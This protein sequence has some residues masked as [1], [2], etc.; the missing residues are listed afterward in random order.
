MDALT[1]AE[2]W[3][4]DEQVYILTVKKMNKVAGGRV[5]IVVN[6]LTDIN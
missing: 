1:H 3:V 5:D 6:Q 2:F 4:D